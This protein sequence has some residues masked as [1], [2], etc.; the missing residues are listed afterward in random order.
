MRR[1]DGDVRMHAVAKMGGMSVLRRLR[2]IPGVGDDG[3][4]RRFTVMRVRDD[5]FEGKKAQHEEEQLRRE[6]AEPADVGGA[7]T[8]R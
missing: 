5:P 4:V 8:S 1:N 3:Y 7:H 2:M 6:T